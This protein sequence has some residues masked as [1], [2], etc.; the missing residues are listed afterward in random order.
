[1]ATAATE[2]ST[3]PLRRR[4]RHCAGFSLKDRSTY[5]S[6]LVAGTVL[7]KT[8]EQLEQ[9]IIPCVTAV[10]PECNQVSLISDGST[11]SMVCSIYM[12]KR[13]REW[14]DTGY[15]VMEAIEVST[16]K[17]EGGRGSAADP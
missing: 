13:L 7:S 11:E 15:E 10:C 2:D 12:W 17:D 5:A 1:M 9:R 4:C 14:I 6:V 8:V 16:V 3:R